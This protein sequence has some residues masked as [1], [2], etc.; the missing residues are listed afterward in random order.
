MMP[1]QRQEIIRL[2]EKGEELS[3]EWA[4][5]LFPPEKR[6][7]ELVYHGKEREEDILANTLAVPLQPVR[8]FGSNGDWSNM[9]IFGDNLQVM[10]SFLEMK[11]AGKLCNADGTLGV[12]LIYIDPPFA[13]KQ[14]FSGSKDQKAYQDKIAGA[15][16]L[17]F[18]RKRLVL[19]KELLADNGLIYVHL[20]Q[21]RSHHIK[22]LMDEIFG[23]SNFLNEIVWKYTKF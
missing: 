4:R 9:L 22:L 23:E 19:L 21:K 18:V 16:F 8:T 3:P 6:E 20:D 14:E 11:K 10:K 15:D 12:K 5:I 2:L 17:E 7:Y 1:E 13:T